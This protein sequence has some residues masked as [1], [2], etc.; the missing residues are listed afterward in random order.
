MS[1][2]PISN[3]TGN[4]LPGTGTTSASVSATSTQSGNGELSPFAQM[5]GTTGVTSEDAAQGAQ[6]YS[7]NPQVPV[8]AQTDSAPAGMQYVPF[9]SQATSLV[10]TVQTY[11]N[12]WNQAT[13]NM[14]P[15]AQQQQILL[16]GQNYPGINPS[17]NPTLAPQTSPYIPGT[18]I[19]WDTLTQEQQ[20]AYMDSVNSGKIGRAHV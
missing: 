12:M 9:T 5:L 10:D 13:Q 3:S 11:M 17:E 15:Q 1:T 19:V 8:T 7:Y 14:S 20:M 16:E 4:Y 18:N 2:S 6:V